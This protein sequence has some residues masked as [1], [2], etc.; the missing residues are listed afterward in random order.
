M[1][2]DVRHDVLHDVRHDVRHDVWYDV[3]HDVHHDVWHDVRHALASHNT[4]FGV[5][6]QVSKLG[7][8]PWGR[9][10]EALQ[11]Q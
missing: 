5:D 2:H 1:R 6:A 10:K 8:L 7:S 11:Q 3:R 4:L 9:L